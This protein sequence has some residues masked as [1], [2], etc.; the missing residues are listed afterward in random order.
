MILKINWKHKERYIKFSGLFVVSV[1]FMWSWMAFSTN[2]ADYYYYQTMFTRIQ[3]GVTYYAVESG[4]YY[5][6]KLAV[7]IGLEYETFLVIYSGVAFLLISNSL[8]KYTK[9]PVFVLFLYF[10]YPY[11][12][13]I[14]QIRHFMA[15]AIFLYAIRYLEEFSIKNLIKYIACVLIATSQQLIAFAFFIFLLVYVK[16][17]RKIIKIALLAMTFLFV[18]NRLLLNTSIYRSILGL[19]DAEIA[20][21]GGLSISHFIQYGA[22]FTFLL[23]FSF[24]IYRKKLNPNNMLFKICMLSAIYIPLMLI[25]FQF[26]RFF[27]SSLFVIYVYIIERLDGLKNK[28]NQVVLEIALSVCL[29]GVGIVL[30]GFGSGYFESMT[31]PIFTENS[32][33]NQIFKLFSFLKLPKRERG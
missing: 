33:W 22:F 19:R 17:S 7:S 1:L 3:H 12:L 24:Y 13:D 28:N 5:L 29:L 26:T 21:A 32:F 25:D 31:V 14:A 15:C 9:K 2:N 11:I 18:G 8:L 23:C 6:C 30:F 10:C 4:F 20:Y 16:D 27:R